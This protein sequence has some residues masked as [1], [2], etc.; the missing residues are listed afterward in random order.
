MEK[1]LILTYYWPPSGGPGVQR[2]LKFAGYLSQFGYQPY[3]VTVDPVQATYPLADLSLNDNVP[4]DIR[5]YFTPTRE[6][7]SV[8][9]KISGRKQVPYSG[10]SNESTDGLFSKITRFIRGNLF[11]PDARTGWNAF[12]L[13]QARKLI[14]EHKIN[15]LITTSPPHSTQ[16]I[17]LRLKKEFPAIKWIA[18]L[19]DPWTDI[20]YY[21]KMLHL[22]PVRRYDLSLEKAVLSGADR[23]VSVSSFINDLFRQKVPKEHESKFAVITNGYD[24]AD[25]EDVDAEPD[26]KT[27]T[28]SYIGTLSEEYD[29][30]GFL[31]AFDSIRTLLAAPACL[32]FTG[33]VSQKW[34]EALMAIPDDVCS[35][36]DHVSHRE[37][38]FRMKQS[39]VLLLIIPRIKQNK[40]IVTGKIFEYM[41]SGRP[42]LG[43]GPVDGDAAAILSATRTGKMFDY[44][45]IE[46]MMK[47]LEDMA[48]NP[49]YFSDSEAVKA[50]SRRRLTE[51]L[52]RLF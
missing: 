39:H 32:R 50:F 19:R 12:A 15:I 21:K 5:V 35:I 6:P 8:Y 49:R 33:S 13:K 18:D 3:V 20:F 48:G 7:Y 45:D 23:V 30:W 28:V 31:K 24:E 40:G 43:I 1:V 2:W 22:P 14:L 37:A 42:I 10:F 52:V 38:I 44:Q 11:I 27:F 34:K 26:N 16:L 47:F 41:A 25:F 46:G 9:K 51:K 4:D 36:T 17:G 29:F